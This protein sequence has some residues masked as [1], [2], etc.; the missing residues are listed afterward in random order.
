M[1]WSDIAGIVFICVTANH[2]GLVKAV[3]DTFDKD[4]PII[5]CP[6]CLSF[7][8]VLIY[9]AF[10]TH[11]IITSL[12][13]SFLAGYAAIWIELIEACIDKFYLMIYETVTED[14]NDTDPADT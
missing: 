13:V 14:N 2:L 1:E 6:K 11:E 12:A 4:L 5:N 8:S 3:E 9:L 7:W 10:T